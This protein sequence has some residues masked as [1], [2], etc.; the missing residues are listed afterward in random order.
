ME[1]VGVATSVILSAILASWMLVAFVLTVSALRRSR[2][3]KATAEHSAVQEALLAAGPALSMIV[4]PGGGVDASQRLVDLL[5]VDTAPALLSDLLAAA[6]R[7]FAQLSDAVAACARSG[8]GFSLSVRLASN[9]RTLVVHGGPAP[10]PLP[11]AA[12]LV[13]FVDMTDVTAETLALTQERDDVGAALGALTRMIEAAPFPMWHR[14][15]DLGLAL[16]NAAYVRAVD[17]ADA[18]SVGAAHAS[19]DRRG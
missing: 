3:A 4:L 1:S 9:G 12:V 10:F 5:G 14:G 6:P 13:W 7:E 17:G 16:V 2:N 15:P 18:R 11:S 8:R 19:R